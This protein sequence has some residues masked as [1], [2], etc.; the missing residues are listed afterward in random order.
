MFWER[1][2]GFFLGCARIL[3]TRSACGK[4]N[5]RGKI[6]IGS[7]PV[8][9]Q[10]V[11]S[12]LDVPE[13]RQHAF[14]VPVDLYHRLT[15]GLR[16]ELLRGTILEKVSKSPTHRKLVEKLRRI[17]AAQIE[18]EFLVFQEAPLTTHDSEPE[19]DLAIVPGP[20]ELYD[21]EHPRTAE[22]VVEIAVSSLEIDRVK[23]TIYAEAGVKEYW[24]V[25]PDLRSVEVYRSPSTA[26]YAEQLTLTSP[27]LLRSTALPN[28]SLDSS[29]LF[30]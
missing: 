15:E 23:A 27:A 14:P 8:H 28:V 13:I 6:A 16:T 21:N 30:A 1:E 20:L 24:I 18:P 7:P 5:V 10:G 4:V 26:G 29:A 17:L 19:P 2:K 12:L 11:S 9:L 3:E 22:L 25:R